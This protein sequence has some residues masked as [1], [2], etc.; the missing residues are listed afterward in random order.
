MSDCRAL[1]A[2]WWVGGAV[3]CLLLFGC[4]HAANHQAAPAP[5]TSLSHS[6]ALPQPPKERNVAT[7]SLAGVQR[8]GHLALSSEWVAFSGCQACQDTDSPPN[9]VFAIRLPSSTPV[10]VAR[11]AFP[12]GQT[13]WVELD[14]DTLIYTDQSRTQSDSQQSVIWTLN[15]INLRTRARTVLDSSHGQRNNWLPEPRTG[16]GY[17]AWVGKPAH[18]TGDGG[19][20]TVARVD[21][22]DRHVVLSQH[23]ESSNLS[24]NDG[25]CVFDA[26]PLPTSPT[27]PTSR[28]VYAVPLA[29]GT[30]QQLSHDGRAVNPTAFHGHVIWSEPAVN[31]TESIHTVALDSPS[32]PRQIFDGVNYQD[33]LGNGFIVFNVANSSQ[34]DVISLDGGP[35]LTLTK[36]ESVPLRVATS[37]DVFAYGTI[38]TAAEPA[39]SIH[40]VTFTT[41]PSPA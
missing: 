11:T 20:L 31:D 3:L 34:L 38:P 23:I 15:S 29:G 39:G 16:Q 13:D 2:G 7:F 18:D 40:L 22:S 36:D 8:A 25:V 17:V 35:P 30:A 14:G 1:R 24:I 19:T 21:G 6:T 26:G 10:V 28:N 41:T 37:G 33:V 32:A 12:A 5:S 9:E 27:A 4:T